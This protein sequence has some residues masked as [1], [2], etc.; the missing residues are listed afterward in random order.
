MLESIH[1]LLREY[2]G[3]YLCGL[4]IGVAKHLAHYFDRESRAEGY[5]GGEGVP[6]Y[7]GGEVLVDAGVLVDACKEVSVIA[8]AYLGELPLVA[9][10]YLDDGR[11]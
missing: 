7:M 2:L 6:A 4:N 10:Q 3:V 9:F 8:E 11:E 5:G 1:D